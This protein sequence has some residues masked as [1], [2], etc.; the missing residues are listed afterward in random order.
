[1]PLY[2]TGRQNLI[3]GGAMPCRGDLVCPGGWRKIWRKESDT[4]ETIS[5]SAGTSLTIPPRTAFQIRNT[6]TEPLF[7]LIV[8]MPPWPGREGA[9]E[10]TGPWPPAVTG[11]TARL[12]AKDRVQT[13]NICRTIAFAV[14]Y[15]PDL[16]LLAF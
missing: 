13:A 7:I 10:A 3:A 15:K 2:V 11:R 14:I 9:D 6:G 1:M 8:T 4:E 16:Y 5:V 12:I